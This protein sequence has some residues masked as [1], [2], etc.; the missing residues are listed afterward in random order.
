MIST[1]P[2]F[3][4]LSSQAGF[5]HWRFDDARAF[6]NCLRASQPWWTPVLGE[7]CSWVFRGQGSSD[8]HLVPKAWRNEGQQTLDHLRKR[9]EAEADRIVASRRDTP[10]IPRD[11]NPAWHR[12]LCVQTV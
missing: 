12:E 4:N 2:P 8:W 6:L 1:A 5:E 7:S 3:K 10:E 11:L 9:S